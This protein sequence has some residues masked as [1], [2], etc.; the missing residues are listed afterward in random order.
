MD[1]KVRLTDWL[2]VTVTVFG[3]LVEPTATL[4]KFRLDGEIDSGAIPLPLSVTV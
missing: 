1:E 2:F 4:P 3:V